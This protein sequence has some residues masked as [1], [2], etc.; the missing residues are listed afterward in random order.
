MVVRDAREVDQ[1]LEAVAEAFRAALRDDGLGPPSRHALACW[2][3]DREQRLEAV[4]EANACNAASQEAALCN[5]IAAHCT[6]M[7]TAASPTS[8]MRSQGHV[9]APEK[10]ADA[11]PSSQPPEHK[12]AAD[13]AAEPHVG[14]SAA[15]APPATRAAAD[16]D[17]RLAS[18]DDA[19][20]LQ[21]VAGAGRASSGATST[22]MAAAPIETHR[23]S[24]EAKQET[25]YT[26]KESD[27]VSCSCR[28]NRG[29]FTALSTQ[30]ACQLLCKQ[31]AECCK[32]KWPGQH[33]LHPQPSGVATR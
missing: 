2:H 8:G 12:L 25:V 16:V 7:L 9:L 21:A 32:T 33:L 23:M 18:S 29:L 31:A 27:L 20:P 14:F 11:D 17:S 13:I 6:T 22:A 19:E 4:R 24:A 30:Q 5:N 10:L 26:M 3:D 15:T 28:P 1:T